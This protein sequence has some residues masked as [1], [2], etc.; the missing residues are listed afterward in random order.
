MFVCDYKNLQLSFNEFH[1]IKKG[2]MPEY[3]DYCLIELKDGRYTA[4]QWYPKS[5][6]GD[7]TTGCF[8]RGMGDSNDAGEVAKWHYLRKYDLTNCLENEKIETIKMGEE[9]EDKHNFLIGGFKSVEDD[10]CPKKEQFCL[11]ILKDGSLAAGRWSPWREKN[12]GGFIYASALAMHNMKKVWAWA[13][14]SPDEIFEREEEREREKLRE[15]ELNK[16]PKTDP[17]KF[18]YGTKIDVYYEKALEKLKKDYPWATMKQMKKRPAY[19][20]AKRRGNY[21][22]GVDNG[23]FNGEQVVS[24]WTEGSTADEFVDFLCE[25][26]RNTVKNYD[27]EIKFK[28]GMDIKVYLDMAYDNVKKDYRWL[29]KSMLKKTWQYDIWNVDGEYEFVR[30]Y[31]DEKD[32]NVIDREIADDLIRSVEYDY[33]QAAL[34]ANPVVERYPV[35]FS[36][37]DAHGWNLEQYIFLKRKTGDFT[38]SVTAG[39]RCAGGSR[40]FFITPNCFEAKTYEEFLDRYLEIVPPGSFGLGKSDLLPDKDLKKFL[41]Y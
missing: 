31:Y 6:K 11:L 25:Y 32:F 8:S 29:D 33:Q 3:G 16:N 17:E 22:F 18:K 28:Y 2:D 12:A 19:V 39:D 7:S 34:N 24:E 14:L 26:T 36:G 1:D 15:A 23:I 9:A 41:G 30:R 35:Q 13:P 38:V 4:G 21:I 20:I 27:P 40:E 37:V 5:T 10:E